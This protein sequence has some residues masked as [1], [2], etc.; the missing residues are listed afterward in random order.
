MARHSDAMGQLR[1]QQ[2]RADF[3]ART[4]RLLGRPRNKRPVTLARYAASLAVVIPALL[5][6]FMALF[7][8]ACALDI[9]EWIA[10]DDWDDAGSE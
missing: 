4:S 1:R 3:W 6:S 7:I 10:G 9:G 2:T 5:V 8:A